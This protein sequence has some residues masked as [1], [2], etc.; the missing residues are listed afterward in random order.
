MTTRKIAV[1]TAGLSQPSST[2]LLA[3]RLTQATAKSLA[4]SEGNVEVTVIELRDLAH[5]ITDNMLTGFPAGKLRDAIKAVTAAD[6]VIAVSPIFS[7]SYSGLFKSFFDVL[8]N[9]ALIGKPTLIAA[10]AG[11]A[12]HSL[13]LEHELR[14]LFAYLRAVVVP[15]AVFA[16]SEDWGAGGEGSGDLSRR[17]ARAA[18]EFATLL[19]GH[20]AGP[21]LS[22]EFSNLVPFEQQLAELQ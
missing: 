19:A 9:K 22:D 2:R 16:A 14:P 20:I 1:I 6:G 4:E 7:A 13:A 17:I 11:T 5:E 12:R 15:T 21:D 18:G 8:D 10:T 3:D